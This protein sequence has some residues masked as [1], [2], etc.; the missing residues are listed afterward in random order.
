MLVRPLHLNAV[1]KITEGIPDPIRVACPLSD[2]RPRYL[3]KFASL[4]VAAELT[5]NESHFGAS[6]NNGFPFIECNSAVTTN[7]DVN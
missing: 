3:D 2:V 1:P 5:M 7:L 6:R 4:R